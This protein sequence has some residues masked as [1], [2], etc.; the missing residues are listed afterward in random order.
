MRI[1]IEL[2]LFI[3]AIVSGEVYYNGTFPCHLQIYLDLA[4]G[5]TYSCYNA[6]TDGSA[7]I[8]VTSSVTYTHNLTI[9]PLGFECI[10]KTSCSL[11]RRSISESVITIHRSAGVGGI[12]INVF[13][14]TDLPLAK[15]VEMPY[16]CLW[17]GYVSLYG[18]TNYHCT[19]MPIEDDVP[20]FIT[21]L[22]PPYMA[23][24]VD[25]T[26]I[27]GGLI[28]LDASN[29]TFPER[30]NPCTSYSHIGSTQAS[31]EI[32]SIR[33]ERPFKAESV[34]VIIGIGTPTSDSDSYRLE[35]LPLA[36]LVLLAT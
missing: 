24:P 27:S 30:C 7:S 31:E 20:I 8:N 3:F 18:D 34:F 11:I 35:V 15:E 1:I 25:S 28:S 23:H 14:Y 16:P 2:S 29:A 22:P 4:V 19:G 26:V 9:A 32:V 10:G 36:M 13:A 6:P 5:L 33:T 21:V 17:S 12:D